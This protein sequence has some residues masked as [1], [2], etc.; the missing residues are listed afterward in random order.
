MAQLD[1]THLMAVSLQD[2]NLT[3]GVGALG[4]D[5]SDAFNSLG[6]FLALEKVAGVLPADGYNQ[7]DFMI[8]KE[9]REAMMYVAGAAG[10][11]GTPW[12][13]LDLPN[14]PAFRLTD[15]CKAIQNVLNTSGFKP[16]L[17][18]IVVLGRTEQ[19]STS[20]YQSYQDLIHNKAG[21]RILP[22]RHSVLML[23][24][25]GFKGW[26]TDDRLNH[27]LEQCGINKG[28]EFFLGNSLLLADLLAW[29]NL[30]EPQ[31]VLQYCS[32]LEMLEDVFMAGQ[33]TTITGGRVWFYVPGL[34]RS[35][36]EKCLQIEIKDDVPFPEE[37]EIITRR[38]YADARRVELDP[39]HGGFSASKP[40]RVTSYDQANRR[41]LPTVL[42]LG[43]TRS[44]EHEI[45][46][47]QK[48]V[49][50]YILNNSTTIMGTSTFGNSTGMR[51]NFV[52]ISGPD[53]SLTWLTNRYRQDPVEELLPLFDEVFT[54]ILKPWYG[55]PRW[56]LIKPYQ[57]HNPLP[58]FPNIIEAAE[59]EFGFSADNETIHC[60]ELSLSLPNPYHFL[61]YVY[62]VRQSVSRLWY[63]G[64]NHGDL[65]MQNILLDER[66]NVYIIDFSDTRPR[67]IVSD[68][69]RLE[70]IFKFEMTRL[71]SEQDLVSFLEF[72]QALA[73][74]D[75]LNQELPFVYHGS[76]PAVE[77]AYRMI[78]R[79]RQYAK[80]VV[81]FENDIIPYLLAM[82][83]WV[84]PI[85]IYRQ[86]TPYGKKAAL[87][88]AALIVD[89][90][91]RLEMNN[92]EK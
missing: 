67:N 63:T 89:Q 34:I 73:G 49:H 53:S 29:D 75:Y 6:P 31:D 62:P 25:A 66:D 27:W 3:F 78:C 79:I 71:E 42:K 92:N 4:T 88:S 26:E 11:S 7:A 80:T 77:K 18:G 45:I 54:H 23:G 24:L 8:V 16:N 39:L 64:I 15:V 43:P 55:Q 37:W 51:Y 12:G 91:K 84:Y 35:G 14:G 59:E 48:Y 10:F 60:P 85:V 83:E 81:I 68:F 76:D 44:I 1:A 56:E 70:P 41:M 19:I 61:K 9:P 22:G 52:G 86:M 13:M 57:D 90:I 28:A 2:L 58:N 74:V 82:L 33:N 36:Q 72:E 38:L 17:L 32:D 20:A 5:R 65:N 46:N 40:F 47:H 21:E 87:Y 30:R 69:A 50:N